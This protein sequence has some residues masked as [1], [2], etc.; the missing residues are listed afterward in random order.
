M[1]VRNVVLK[2][3]AWNWGG[4]T[5]DAVAAFAITPFLVH[6]LGETR[7][8]LWILIGSLSSYFGLLDLGVRASVGRYAA[9]H[10]AKA[11]RAAL[12]ATVST[13]LAISSA[14]GLLVLAA[15]FVAVWIF[16]RAFDVPADQASAVRLALVLVCV[17][18]A[19]SF[20]LNI[21]D[22][23]LWAAQR[24][25]LL[26]GVDI[27]ATGLRVALTCY[28]IEKG[29]G[30][31]GLAVLTLA[32]TLASGLVKI[33]LSFREDRRLRIGFGYVSLGSA[34]EL[35]GF[36]FCNF[37]I[38]LT[39]MTRAQ[40]SPFLIG[41]LIGLPLVTVYSIAKRLYDYAERVVGS[42][43]GV[44]GPMATTLHAQDRHERQRAMFVEGGRYCMAFSLFFLTA[45]A[46]LG[47][48]FFLLWIG[49]KLPQAATLLLILT[50]GECL[51]LSQSITGSML[52]GMGRL[53][54]ITWL[55]VVELAVGLPLAAVLAGPWGLVGI[56][57]ALAATGTVFRGLAVMAYGCHVAG[58][59]LSRYLVRSL[60]PPLL[61]A[62]LPGVALW[63]V[64]AWHPPATWLSFFADAALFTAL[65]AISCLPLL[66]RE[67]LASLLQRARVGLPR[68]AVV[69]VEGD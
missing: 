54:I 49:P 47:R 11:D 23:T 42:A 61:L 46:L 9:Y 16:F 35:F 20:P 5:C 15:T 13:S 55:Y 48:P 37:A 14:V 62:T 31:V 67:R 32:I 51:P 18:L 66:G 10:R 3:I 68:R 44:V 57:L 59:W 1:S 63:A 36:G 21:F 7:Y 25:D 50:A 69:G 58:V 65:Y 64:V 40:M 30:L 4:M 39:R 2:N 33:L 41:T 52:M 53:K 22:G 43:T 60:L 12:N 29:Y 26:N 17:N 28:A 24:F 6:R 19:V 56:C 45:F 8:G 27:P 38:T 34:R